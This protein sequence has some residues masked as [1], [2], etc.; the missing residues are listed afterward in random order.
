MGFCCGIGV[1][2]FADLEFWLVLGVGG[3]Q[4]QLL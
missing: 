2:W 4:R 3:L 1:Q